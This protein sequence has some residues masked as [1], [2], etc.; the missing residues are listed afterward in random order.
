MA[1][2]MIMKPM[3]IQQSHYGSV[4]QYIIA[5]RDSISDAN[6]VTRTPTFTPFSPF[7]ASGMLLKALESELHAWVKIRQEKYLMKD[8]AAENLTIDE[9][10]TI[11]NEAIDEGRSTT[12]PQ[13]MYTPFMASSSHSC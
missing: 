5:L 3:Q 11:C 12:D 10:M 1:H 4:D 6:R 7:L 9:F 2:N 13:A 8:N